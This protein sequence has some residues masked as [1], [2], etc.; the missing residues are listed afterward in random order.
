M[1]HT[2]WRCIAEEMGKVGVIAHLAER[3][4]QARYVLRSVG[5]L[6]WWEWPRLRALL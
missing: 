3:S 4:G 5:G 6:A 2:G 1:S